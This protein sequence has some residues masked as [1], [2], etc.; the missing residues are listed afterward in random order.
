MQGG[1][2]RK[3]LLRLLIK[4]GGDKEPVKGY[5]F[6][7]VQSPI[8]QLRRYAPI[9]IAAIIMEGEL[10]EDYHA[11]PEEVPNIQDHRRIRLLHQ[12]SDEG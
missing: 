2:P 8:G 11:H 7:C 9:N 3:G 5:K 12:G 1:E 4:S 6:G 10:Q